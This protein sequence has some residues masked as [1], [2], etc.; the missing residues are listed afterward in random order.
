MGLLKTLTVNGVSYEVK[1]VVPAS[2]V[3]LRAAGWVGSEGS[4]SQVVPLVGVTNH[5]KVDLQ[6]TPEQVET[7]LEK[8]LAFTTENNNGVVTV[9]SVGDKP[10]DDYTIQVTLIE[11]EGTPPIRGNTVG[12]PNPQVDWNQTDSKKADFIKNKPEVATAT[13]LRSHIADKPTLMR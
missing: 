8:T 12:L 5:T 1:P 9:Y 4:Y 7:F 2:Y 13:D 6:P 10:E 11:A 3:T